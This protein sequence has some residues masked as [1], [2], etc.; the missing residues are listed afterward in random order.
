MCVYIY[1]NKEINGF[2][3]V[4]ILMQFLFS[5]SLATVVTTVLAIQKP[6][7]P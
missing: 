7:F 1:E 3:Q 6:F 2:L 4:Y 5:L